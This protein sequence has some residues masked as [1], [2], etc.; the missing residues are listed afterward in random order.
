MRMWVQKESFLNRS[1]FANIVQNVMLIYQNI[2]SCLTDPELPVRVESALAL[3]TLIS[4]EIIQEAMR[5]NIADIM[6]E[7]LKLTNEVEHDH[8]PNVMEE[9]VEVFASE[10]TP[11]AVQLTEQLRDTY[12]R[13][14]SE[15]IEKGAPEDESLLSDDKSITA[16]GVLQT[17][18][19]LI[20]TLE[21]TPEVLLHLEN[22][23]VPVI[24]VTLNNHLYDLFNEVF[25]IID[26]CTFSAKSIS[27]TMWSIFE[28][29]H[30]TFKSRADI[31][32]EDML[33][34]LDNYIRY[35]SNMFKQNENYFAAIIDIIQTIFTHERLGAVDRICGCKL[36]E[37]LLLSLRGHADKYVPWFIETVMTILSNEQNVMMKSYKLHLMEVVVN[38]IYYNPGIALSVLER[39]GWTNKFFTLWFTSIDSFRRVHDKK[40]AICAISALLTLPANQIPQTI[41]PGWHRLLQGVTRLFETLPLAIKNREEANASFGIEDFPSDESD[42]GWDAR[43]DEGWDEGAE[44]QELEEEA[45]YLDFLKKEAAFDE[46]DFEEDEIEEENL[47]ESQLDPVEPYTLF[48]DAFFGKAYVVLIWCSRQMLTGENQGSEL[49]NHNSTNRR[50][51][52]SLQR[53]KRC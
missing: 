49:R 10:L 4:H 14:I 53:N 35:G 38:A 31:Y 9:F 46:G 13:I 41:L 21:S 39:G 26:S 3:R 43:D 19:T 40:L 8:L 1:L 37:S 11:F 48:R 45:K 50:Q 23:L 36:A 27:P 24:T 15:I 7:L 30:Q 51:R 20:L 22:V 18:G 17:I 29:V 6:Q 12:L 32:V 16:L 2:L 33:P 42:G 5:A 25:E 47:I 34:A 44:E 52:C 28:L